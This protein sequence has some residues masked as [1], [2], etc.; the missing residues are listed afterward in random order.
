MTAM[1]PLKIWIF[2]D[3]VNKV[4]VVE[5]YAK[6]VASSRD[7]RGGTTSWEHGKYFQPR[8]QNFKK[9]RH[10]PQGQGGF[11]RNTHDQ[12]Q[13]AKGRGNQSK[14]SL[15]LT[16]VRCG[17][18]HPNDFCKIGI[19]G[20]FNCRL[21]GHIVRDCTRQ[22]NPNAGQSQHKGRVFTMNARD[23]AKADPLMRGNCLI[24]DK[25]L[26]ALY[27]IG[28]SHSFISF[29][30]VEEL[31]LKVS[32]LAFELHVHTP[33]Q[34]IVTRL[35]CR[36]VGFKLE[37]RDFVHDLIC[38]PMIGLEIILGFDW[39]SKN[40]EKLDQIQVVRNFL[41]VFSEDISEFP[42]QR[43]IEFTIEL[44]PGAR[45]VSIALYKMAPIELVEL[46]THLEELLNKRFIRS[47]VS[48][49]G[50]PV[51]L[52]KKKDRG[53]R[54]CVD[55]RQ[56]NKVTVKNKYPLPR[57]DDLMDQLQRAGVFSKID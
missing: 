41:E 32:E 3:L 37:G 5:E 42:P 34:T 7:T 2:S 47:S 48:P 27:D 21:P 44:V 1:A 46:K 14:I 8:G 36:H 19:G 43:E 22:K 51:L 40:W 13:Y 26:V 45:P 18:F 17:R 11:G 57:I 55:Y 38:L 16:C 29:G 49:W 4:R 28:A 33:H 25:I 50:A 20:C 30:K 6:M 35:G 54:L 10:A 9:E 24:G 56:L 39:L 12:F 23:A 31:G 52:V 53:M 15:D